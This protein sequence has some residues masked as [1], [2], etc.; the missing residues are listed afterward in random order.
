[1]STN[2]A[3]ASILLN[4]GGTGTQRNSANAGAGTFTLHE[5]AGDFNIFEKNATV[6]TDTKNI[7][8]VDTDPNDA[9]FDD[10]LTAPTLPTV[11]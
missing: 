9:A 1:M 8:P 5:T 3:A 2:G 6:V 10:S 11:P 4:L 7:G